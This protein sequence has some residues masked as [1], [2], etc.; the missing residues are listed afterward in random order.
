MESGPS[1]VTGQHCLICQPLPFSRARNPH[2]ANGRLGQT[3]S[4]RIQVQVHI[5]YVA[6]CLFE[7]QFP[8]LSHAHGDPKLAP[9]QCLYWAVFIP[10]IL[11]PLRADN[12]VQGPRKL[13]NGKSQI[14]IG[15]YRAQSV[16]SPRGV[17][18]QICRNPQVEE[19]SSPSP[20]YQWGGDGKVCVSAFSKLSP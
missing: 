6:L 4:V 18:G 8:Y 12:S 17:L 13:S 1:S 9:E 7:P 2:L 19:T 3:S 15:C 10:T 20:T 14:L 5:S 16:T 11:A